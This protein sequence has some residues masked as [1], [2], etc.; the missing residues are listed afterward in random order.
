MEQLYSKALD[1]DF[2]EL[3]S[4]AERYNLEFDMWKR[5]AGMV[6][7]DMSFDCG[8][9]GKH[10]DMDF[11]DF[12]GYYMQYD[13]DKVSLWNNG[14]CEGEV[15]KTD[16]GVK[17]KGFDDVVVEP[18]DTLMVTC[19]QLCRSEENMSLAIEQMH[20][21]NDVIVGLHYKDSIVFA[22]NEDDS[23]LKAQ[24]YNLYSNVRFASETEIYKALDAFRENHL[25]LG[26]EPVMPKLVRCFYDGQT[27][28]TDEEYD[29]LDLRSKEQIQIDNALLE[30]LKKEIKTIRQDMDNA[31]GV[32]PEHQ[33]FVY[34]NVLYATDYFRNDNV[35]F[36][37]NTGK[38]CNG[39]LFV[40]GGEIGLYK[41]FSE[42]R[43]L[44]EPV[45]LFKDC[46]SALEHIR[47][48]LLNPKSIKAAQKDYQQFLLSQKQSKGIKI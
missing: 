33:P 47:K 32:A 39:A 8:W 41:E 20:K 21:G 34:D 44:G 19:G 36:C 3:H 31:V 38:S 28:R 7:A 37:Y 42:G 29:P 5:M 6:M 43:K 26:P 13:N 2:Q 9:R 15:I 14:V 27:V 30:H 35:C 1:N 16:G 23:D 40:R 4:N 25:H 46:N 12:G 18:G 48:S 22:V 24:I 10:R 11:S 45:I 17:L